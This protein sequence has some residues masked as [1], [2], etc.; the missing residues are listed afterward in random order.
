MWLTDREHEHEA[1]VPAASTVWIVR[2][3]IDLEGG[4]D[5]FAACDFVAANRWLNSGESDGQAG[6]GGDVE[7]QFSISA[8]QGQGMQ[9]LV[10]EVA[11]FARAYFGRGEHALIGRQRHRELLRNTAEMLRRSIGAAQLGEELAAEDLRIAAHYLGQ[12][13][14]R[15]D[16]EDL[17]GVIFRE[18]CVGK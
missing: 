11:D 16:V 2:N 13:L 1:A 5:G 18:F 3:K 9:A 17:L 8:A 4:Q 10:A 12:L 15:V 14:G 7:R 6:L